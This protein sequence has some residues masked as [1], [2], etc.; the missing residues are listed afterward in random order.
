MLSS[1]IKYTSF[2]QVYCSC[3]FACFLLK[4]Q[5]RDNV[6]ERVCLQLFACLLPC[7]WS[8][9]G[10][11]IFTNVCFIC[12]TTVR[13]L[14]SVFKRQTCGNL[15]ENRYINVRRK[16]NNS[17]RDTPPLTDLARTLFLHV[18]AGTASQTITCSVRHNDSL[19]VCPYLSSHCTISSLASPP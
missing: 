3:S 7:H 4:R 11:A 5:T 1:V 16:I 13:L 9:K 10:V 8:D 15:Y 14:A 18:S 6:Y 19:L 2:S 17:V 12:L